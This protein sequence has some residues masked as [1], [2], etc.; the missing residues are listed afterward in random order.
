M[1]R[2]MFLTAYD[3]PQYLIE[4]LKSLRAVRGFTEWPL[5]VKIEPS[6]MQEALLDIVRELEHPDIHVNV[7]PQRYGVLH[8][9]WVGFE[10]LFSRYDFVV[11]LEDDLPVSSDLLEYFEWASEVYE[12]H[13]RVA[14]VLGYTEEDGSD[15]GVR[16]S[17][18]FCPWVWGTW[19]DRW[20]S[21]IG[22]TWDHDYSTYNG[23][24]GNQC[25]PVRTEILT[26]RGWLR[27]DQVQVGDKTIGYNFSTGRSEWTRI[28]HVQTPFAAPTVSIF[29]Q[30]KEFECTPEHKWVVERVNH[31]TG[32]VSRSLVET[33]DLSPQ[34]MVLA[35]AVADTG[36]GLN[37][38]DQEAAL[39]GWVAG[40]GTVVQG[41]DGKLKLSVSQKK[42]E[43]FSTLD[44]V[45]S[46]LPHSVYDYGDVRTWYLH[47]GAARDLLERAGHPKADA[48]EQ[49][50][51]M[52][53]SQRKAWLSAIDAAEGTD[54]G[55]K[56]RIYQCVGPVSEAIQ[57]AI[58]LEG[59]KSSRSAPVEKGEWRPY[60]AHSYGVAR[61]QAKIP[62]DSGVQDVWCVTTALGTWTAR[63]DDKVMLTG[64]SGWDWNLN[65]R[66][67]PEHDFLSVVPTASRVQ[68]IGVYGVHGTPANF[69][70]TSSF[71]ADRAPV[72]YRQV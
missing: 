1:K 36:D 19:R 15:D 56:R 52:S 50:L 20:K 29:G 8:H 61:P 27:H 7:N 18:E 37:V 43:W 23:Y 53:P 16:L 69:R 31:R 39:L 45:F 35:S 11:R 24:P 28:T 38:T 21:V 70:T 51:K 13:P 59:W 5:Y 34:S 6:H 22:P 60:Y 40:D 2:A 71:V 32:Q 47:T 30:H 54:H 63:Q 4:T 55:A 10:Q 3:R 68:N 12:F 33:K 25:V 9:P 42:V 67:F 64:N 62:K 48:F 41:E 72:E 58:Y 49:V 26:Q 17:A 65:T 66:I 57:L 46:G 14:T 44:E